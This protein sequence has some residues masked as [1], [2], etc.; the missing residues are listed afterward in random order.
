M[1]SPSRSSSS[2]TISIPM[3]HHSQPAECSNEE[4]HAPSH[5]EQ[6]QDQPGE[7]S[8]Q[9]ESTMRKASTV[10]CNGFLDLEKRQSTMSATSNTSRLESAA[11]SLVSRI[12]SRHPGQ[13]A[14]F[15]HQLSHIKT[16]GD[17]IVDFD[18]GDDP[19]RPLN[20]NF[21]KKA[22]TTVLYGLTTFGKY[23]NNRL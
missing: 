18:G 12:R 21:Q 13:T 15:S 1:A 5:D 4:Q 14:R 8:I 17:V 10:P 3:Q 20:W 16:N 9:H 22:V 23:Q 2:S 19:Y 11:Q 7:N 6:L